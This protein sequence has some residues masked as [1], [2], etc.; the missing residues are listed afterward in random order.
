MGTVKIVGH[1]DKVAGVA[2][3]GSGNGNETCTIPVIGNKGATLLSMADGVTPKSMGRQPQAN[4]IKSNSN[5]IK[6]I[7]SLDPAASILSNMALGNVTQASGLVEN[8]PTCARSMCDVEH[9]GDSKN[10]ISGNVHHSTIAVTNEETV[11]NCIPEKIVETVNNCIPEKIVETVNN[12]IPEKIVETGNNCIPEKIVETVDNSIPETIVETGN[13]CIPDLAN[14]HVANGH[15]AN[16]IRE[17]LSGPCFIPCVE[18]PVGYRDDYEPLSHVS[19]DWL[20]IPS[21]WTRG[22]GGGG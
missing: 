3:A 16:E 19:L 5:N 8:K 1:Y 21:M 13:N 11:N 17:I 18:L 20:K 15:V 4:V 22:G 2:V 12:C 9:R 10:S 6:P 14:G 7:S